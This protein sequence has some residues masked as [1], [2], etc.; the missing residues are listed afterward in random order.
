M[1]WLSMNDL[2]RTPWNW[3]AMNAQDHRQKTLPG[4]LAGHGVG[5]RDE[6]DVSLPEPIVNI[7]V[8]TDEGF[9]MDP[10]ERD[11]S[12]GIPDLR[13]DS[14]S[15]SDLHNSERR[16]ADRSRGGT[17]MK[18]R[19]QR[20]KIVA[21]ILAQCEADGPEHARVVEIPAPKQ[22]IIVVSDLHISAGRT[23][24]GSYGGTEN[25]FSDES[26]ARMLTHMMEDRVEKRAR[27]SMLVINGDFVDFLRIV[28][29][30]ETDADFLEWQ[31]ILVSIGITDRGVEE[32][33][34]VVS[35]KERDIGLKTHD[36]KSV[37]KLHA[38]TKG[39]PALFAG[40]ASW[41]QHGHSLVVVKGNHDLEWYWPAVRNF[42]RIT[43][44]GYVHAGNPATPLHEHLADILPR[45]R[46]VDDA[47]IID[48]QV[49]LEHGHRYDKFSAVLGSPTWGAS[50]LELNIPF[51]SFFN[52]YLINKLELIYPFLD[53]VRPR[54]NILHMLMRERFFLGLKVLFQYV[55]FTIDM[56][57]KRY[58]HYLLKPLV[59]YAFALGLPLL[60]TVILWGDRLV[61]LFFAGNG[62]TTGVSS[63][64]DVILRYV[65]G[66]L[67]DTAVLFLG[68]LLSRFVSFVQLSEP[69]DLQ[70]PAKETMD[71]HPGCRL[72]S[73][74]HT[75]N[76]EQI[77]ENGRWY[78]NSGSWIPVIEASSAALRED[79]TYALIYLERGS[80]GELVVHPLQRW[81]DD[82]GRI[83]PLVIVERK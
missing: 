39:H 25:F 27:S 37:W 79:K 65:G 60:V 8:L 67:N 58:A 82:A 56:I 49:Y 77:Q 68:Y 55:P 34:A 46:F 26:F 2:M 42:L 75:H 41:V 61:P 43:L 28:S 33:K 78:I 74:G 44:A 66:V 69:E 50:A 52:R 10:G 22:D 1:G 57:P 24:D 4:I 7:P 40:L 64:G 11:R 3:P 16:T 32:L 6:A 17:S 54:Q 13:Q 21:S 51:G 76:P 59:G 20:Q 35:D 38:A 70:G 48:G 15:V 62:Q 19:S 36:F 14:F 18:V 12:V 29:V 5:V 73:M 63:L 83:E 72:I 71:A 31:N 30:P 47:C 23:P 81:N 80:K 9:I 53:N 45:I